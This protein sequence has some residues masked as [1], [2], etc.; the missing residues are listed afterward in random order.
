MANDDNINSVNKK[1]DNNLNILSLETLEPT[2]LFHNIKNVNNLYENN[3]TSNNIDVL[4]SFGDTPEKPNI[5]SNS[6]DNQNKEACYFKLSDFKKQ[7]KLFSGDNCDK[8]IQTDKLKLNNG[9]TVD[10][11]VNI[12]NKKNNNNLNDDNFFVKNFYS[13]NDNIQNNN[14]NNLLKTPKFEVGSKNSENEQSKI[15]FLPDINNLDNDKKTSNDNKIL[16]LKNK[17]EIFKKISKKKL[18]NLK[19]TPK[20]SKNLKMNR[21]IKSKISKIITINKN[22]NNTVNNTNTNVYKNFYEIKKRNEFKND[23]VNININISNNITNKINNQDIILRNKSH[24]IIHNRKIHSIK[25]RNLF[26]NFNKDKYLEYTYTD[27]QNLGK[28]DF[29]NS[30][31]N[32]YK[33]FDKKI[34]QN[35]TVLNLN[36]LN[37]SHKHKINSNK[38]NSRNSSKKYLNLKNSFANK[39]IKIKGSCTK[40]DS[41]KKFDKINICEN[42]RKKSNITR[43]GEFYHKKNII[44]P[45]MNDDKINI[46]CIYSNTKIN[47]NNNLMIKNMKRNISLTSEKF[48]KDTLKGKKLNMSDKQ[49]QKNHNRIKRINNHENK[50]V[51]SRNKNNLTKNKSCILDKYCNTFKHSM[52]K[53]KTGIN[54]INNYYNNKLDKN[55]IG[56]L[57]DKKEV[58]SNKCKKRNNSLYNR[59]CFNNSKSM[60][61]KTFNDEM[62]LLKQ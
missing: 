30:F 14:E 17:K 27:F 37:D 60:N 50:N 2:H 40:L 11:S 26:N 7:L 13:F 32:Y 8:E 57:Y 24:N 62:S 28:N 3:K 56:N 25:C 58:K 34:I 12:N 47:A 15:N 46:N 5:I 53:S 20:F 49:L 52:N 18:L 6:P 23:N 61:P 16:F 42:F 39:N 22:N 55:K 48:L 41:V 21:I 31:H 45:K 9:K 1:F 36:K 35:R 38:N 4:F 33:S 59:R 44:N 51:N 43:N 19:T 10:L 54:N 29:F